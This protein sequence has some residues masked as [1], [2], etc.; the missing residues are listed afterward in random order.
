MLLEK[1]Q[2]PNTPGI[3]KRSDSLEAQHPYI[4]ME[5]CS[6]GDLRRVEMVYSLLPRK[7]VNFSC[8]QMSR[9]VQSGLMTY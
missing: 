4:I 8:V 6:S 3:E 7:S 1:S 5:Y 2:H 9:I